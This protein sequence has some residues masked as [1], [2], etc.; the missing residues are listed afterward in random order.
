MA[1]CTSGGSPPEGAPFWPD[2]AETKVEVMREDFRVP[3]FML[4]AFI[5][6]PPTL[7]GLL[8]PTL[9]SRILRVLHVQVNP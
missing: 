3:G 9:H 5:D 4:G 1:A 7:T 2:I 8:P 6:V